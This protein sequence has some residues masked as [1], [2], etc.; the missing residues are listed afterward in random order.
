MMTAGFG[1][2]V[3]HMSCSA[4]L[5]STRKGAFGCGFLLICSSLGNFEAQELGTLAC[6]GFYMVPENR[7]SMLWKILMAP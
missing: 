4:G 6:L 5:L 3:S 7:S 2:P 1:M